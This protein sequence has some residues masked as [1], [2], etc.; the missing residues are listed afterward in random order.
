MKV[1]FVF[2]SKYSLPRIAD[3]FLSF[4]GLLLRYPIAQPGCSLQKHKTVG[5]AVQQNQEVG[6]VN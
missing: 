5:R 3:G 4:H 1:C 2:L 6:C